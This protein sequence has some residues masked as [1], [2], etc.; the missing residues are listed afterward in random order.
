MPIDSYV[1]HTFLVR[2]LPDESGTCN[3]G[4]PYAA[5]SL[6]PCKSA[7]VTVNDHDDQVIHILEDM[8]VEVED[9]DSKAKEI[10]N[11]ITSK[12]QEKVKKQIEADADMSPDEAID[13]FA[14]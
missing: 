7:W 12:C 5:P 9:S 1:N 4:T 13:A 2:E 8:K 6:S 10:T 11:S 3:P 14:A